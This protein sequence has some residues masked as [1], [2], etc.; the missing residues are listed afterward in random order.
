MK[1]SP[2]TKNGRC[3]ILF[4]Y[5]KENIFAKATIIDTSPNARIHHTQIEEG[6][7]KVRIDEVMK[8]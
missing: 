3:C 1:S 6:C 4:E 8:R 2:G 5:R 7:C